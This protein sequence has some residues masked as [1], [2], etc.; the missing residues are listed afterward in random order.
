M[1]QDGSKRMRSVSPPPLEPSSPSVAMGS[2]AGALPAATNAIPAAVAEGLCN[3]YL[4]LSTPSMDDHLQQPKGTLAKVAS[5]FAVSPAIFQARLFSQILRDGRLFAISLRASANFVSN[6]LLQAWNQSQRHSQFGRLVLPADLTRD[7]D[8]Q[9]FVIHLRATC[10]EA[11]ATRDQV[12][13]AFE[14]GNLHQHAVL[15]AVTRPWGIVEVALNGRDNFIEAIQFV[16][17]AKGGALLIGGKLF[18][19]EIPMTTW[20]KYAPEGHLKFVFNVLANMDE[21][22]LTNILRQ[23]NVESFVVP[24]DGKKPRL[25]AYVPPSAKGLMARIVEVGI[26]L[27]PGTPL[28]GNTTLQHAFTATG[29]A[30][31]PADVYTRERENAFKASDAAKSRDRDSYRS[32]VAT[33]SHSSQNRDGRS[34][35]PARASPKPVSFVYNPGQG[36]TPAPAV[37]TRSMSRDDLEREVRRL[38]RQNGQE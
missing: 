20:D 27:P 19:C 38:R 34:P 16:R 21:L 15:D 5:L 11:G 12:M 31:V 32:R 14:G 30:W 8:G 28:A 17:E 9:T 13:V 1:N 6:D 2:G 10:D 24:L 37:D 23:Q 29:Q 26:T 4:V 22:L 33:K 25:V 7:L 18:L 3:I 35:K 36:A